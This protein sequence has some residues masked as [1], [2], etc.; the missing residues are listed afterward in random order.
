MTC[1]DM[2]HNSWFQKCLRD[3]IRQE[4]HALYYQ[5]SP[6]ALQARRTSLSYFGQFATIVSKVFGKIPDV[7][8]PTD[9]SAT[10]R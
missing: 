1:N 5:A 6:L 9:S 4:L 10:R 2:W 7:Y 3:G 8:I